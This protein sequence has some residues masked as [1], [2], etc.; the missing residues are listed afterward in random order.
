MIFTCEVKTPDI[1]DTLYPNGVEIH[2]ILNRIVIE[3][4]KEGRIPSKSLMK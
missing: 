3:K 2:Q 1:K 4:L